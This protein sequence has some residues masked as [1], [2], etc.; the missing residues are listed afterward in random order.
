MYHSL[1]AEKY[2]W[3]DSFA[4]NPIAHFKTE[5]ELAIGL[6]N[7][8]N[9]EL[10]FL[11]V[12]TPNVP[13]DS[14]GPAV[15]TIL[16][17]YGYKNVYGSLEYPVHAL[18]IRDQHRLI[19]SKYSSPFI[20]AVD[21]ALGKKGQAGLITIKNGPLYPGKGVGKKLPPVGNLEITGVF[22]ILDQ[23]HALNLLVRLSTCISNGILK[24]LQKF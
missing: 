6:S 19:K 12:G 10:V 9:N 3:I 15:G 11:C 2:H 23:P 16:K 18:N 22:D 21:A 1:K 17:R 13:G 8:K 4:D 20:I 14:L 7:L 5:L 24:T